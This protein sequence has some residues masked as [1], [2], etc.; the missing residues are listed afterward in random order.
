MSLPF[1]VRPP[2]ENAGEMAAHYVAAIRTVQPRGPYLLGGWSLG[3]NLAFEVARQLAL[4]LGIPFKRF[5]MSEYM[6]KH[7]VSRLVGAPPGLYVEGETL[8][9]KLKHGP[10]PVRRA[11]RIAG[12]IADGLSHCACCGKKQKEVEILLRVC[13]ILL[14]NLFPRKSRQT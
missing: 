7:T 11:V 3:G 4:S 12:E 14:A 8:K 1:G 6:E 2:H 13:L 9:E 10:I 5:D